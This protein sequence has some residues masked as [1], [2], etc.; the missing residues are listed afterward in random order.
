MAGI[1]TE[2]LNG[3]GHVVAHRVQRVDLA[4][5]VVAHLPVTFLGPLPQF[6]DIPEHQD[7]AAGKAGEYI[8]GG[9]HRG[10][11]CVVAVVDHPHAVGGDLRHGAALDRLHRAQARGDA[12]QAQTDG[13]RGG[14]G[15]QG[16]AD[17]VGAKQIQLHRHAAIR[18]VQGKGRTAT[19]ITAD[20]AGMEIGLRVVQ[21]EA[22]NSVIARALAPDVECLVGQV[23]DGRA[24]LAQAFEDFTLG[25]DDFSGPPNSPTWA[26]PA[27]L[28]M[29]TCGRVRPTV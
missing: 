26:V 13:M 2:R 9:A 8:N 14:G 15:G 10:G 21:G 23:E 24:A 18:P 6:A 7:G 20:G 28:M 4:A 5:G 11:I 19:G 17:V 16:I 1:G 27:L 29:T 22:D 3:M 25:L 12:A